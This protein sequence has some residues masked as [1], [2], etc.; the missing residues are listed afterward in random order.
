MIFFLLNY[1]K[2]NLLGLNMKNFIRIYPNVQILNPK[3]VYIN[4][5]VTLYSSC[6]IKALKAS[7]MENNDQKTTNGKVIIGD[8]SS[9]GEFSFINSLKL[10]EIG[11]NVLIAQH[12]YIGDIEHV[13][14]DRSIPIRQQSNF[15]N[16]VV[17]KD[18]VW[19]GCGV[20][21][22]S[23]VIIGKGSVIAAGAVVTKDVPPYTLFGGVP[24]KKIKDIRM[25]S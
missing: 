6:I 23:G 9:I 10:I 22:M 12:C 24:A 15:A 1:L 20:K 14:N 19:I 8:N 5:N 4:E 3:N 16:K 13:F 21:I 17:I 25:E 11:Q 18:D 2:W 7:I